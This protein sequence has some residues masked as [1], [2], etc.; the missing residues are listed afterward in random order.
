MAID[1]AAP[2][3]VLVHQ[4]PTRPMVARTVLRI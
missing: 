3:P 1:A 2:V 4:I